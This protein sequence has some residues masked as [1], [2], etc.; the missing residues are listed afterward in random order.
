MN[1]KPL[2]IK[3]AEMKP[4]DLKTMQQTASEL[5][6]MIVKGKKATPMRKEQRSMVDT[7]DSQSDEEV[8][9]TIQPTRKDFV[10]R[11]IIQ[12]DIIQKDIVPK[13]FVQKDFVQKD[14]ESGMKEFVPSGRKDD[15]A[16]DKM[17][18]EM[19]KQRRMSQL[20]MTKVKN[21]S[22]KQAII[23]N[24]TEDLVNALKSSTM[25]NLELMKMIASLI[26][27]LED[28]NNEIYKLSNADEEDRTAKSIRMLSGN[29]MAETIKY[30]EDGIGVAGKY[31]DEPHKKMFTDAL[32]S[33]RNVM[34]NAV[35]PV[36]Y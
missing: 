15:I 11:D 13:D 17:E 28:L 2:D 33:L 19:A 16:Q 9:K 4:L 27:T 14:K 6:N 25:L 5:K 10:Q 36:N 12:K 32:N 8:V 3:Q 24:S 20:A 18:L 29:V 22:K 26:S 21:M 31:I 35:D 23:T 7:D 34:K 30:L 1:G